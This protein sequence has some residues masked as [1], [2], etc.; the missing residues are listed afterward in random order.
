MT[1][2]YVCWAGYTVNCKTKRD[3]LRIVV[4]N[5]LDFYETSMGNS[6]LQ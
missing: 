3:I 4:V 1:I 2:G 6:V 5:F